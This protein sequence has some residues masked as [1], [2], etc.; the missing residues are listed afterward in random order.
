LKADTSRGDSFFVSANAL[1]S[2]QRA[3]RIAGTTKA[4][5]LLDSD[6]EESFS[7]GALRGQV[8]AVEASNEFAQTDIFIYQ[9]LEVFPKSTMFPLLR[10]NF[11]TRSSSICKEIIG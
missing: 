5:R 6:K 10:K 3:T 7:L 1:L 4:R 2:L 11:P 9:S 8:L